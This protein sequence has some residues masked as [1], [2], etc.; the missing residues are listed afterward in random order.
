MIISTQDNYFNVR[1]HF[2]EMI[3]VVFKATDKKKSAMHLP[4][5]G[6]DLS[7]AGPR[8]NI[9]TVFPGIEFSL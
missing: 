1:S 9:K 2:C 8:L 6:I 3:Q 7:I 4:W 5:H